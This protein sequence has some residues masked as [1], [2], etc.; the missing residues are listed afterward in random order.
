MVAAT[1]VRRG[2]GVRMCLHL[3]QPLARRPR[4]RPGEA[5]G[6]CVHRLGHQVYFR[7]LQVRFML[8][9]PSGRRRTQTLRHVP[10][11]CDGTALFS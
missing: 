11:H 9:A 3:V 2:A 7:A 8:P 6:S 4:L 1:I 10:K 5:V